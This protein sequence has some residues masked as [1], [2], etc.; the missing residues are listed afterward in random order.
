[1]GAKNIMGLVGKDRKESIEK[2][3][4]IFAQCDMK[5]VRVGVYDD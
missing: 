4:Q 3:R 2:A 5:I 1:M